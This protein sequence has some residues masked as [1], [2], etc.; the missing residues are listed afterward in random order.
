MKKNILIT[1]GL[2]YLGTKIS[3]I[4]SGV[5]WYNR[6]VVIDKN[7]HSERVS[8]LTKWNIEFYQGD[9]LDYN[10]IKKYVSE[11]PICQNS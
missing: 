6:I 2:G 5:S 7:F 10:F 3:E 8:Q 1:G 9:I 11:A 4:Y